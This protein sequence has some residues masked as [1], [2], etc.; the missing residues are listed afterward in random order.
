MLVC[1]DYVENYIQGK[2][3]VDCYVKSPSKVAQNKAVL[4]DNIIGLIEGS[5]GFIWRNIQ[6]GVSYA[7]GG[8]AEPEYPEELVRES[9]NNAIAHRNYNTDRF[10]II[11]IRPQNC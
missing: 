5:F 9:I 10:V 8:T 7:K 2:C 11:E 3:E 6:V 1:G 4:N